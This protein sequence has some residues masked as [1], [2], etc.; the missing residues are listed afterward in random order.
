[1]FSLTN[2]KDIIN[3]QA[4]KA[5]WERLAYYSIAVIGKEDVRGIPE[6]GTGVPICYKGKYFIITCSHIIRGVAEN[7]L[8]FVP[9]T[10]EALVHKEK[11]ELV[12]G[13]KDKKFRYTEMMSLPIKTIHLASPAC[14]DLAAIE[15]D[16]TIK[17]NNLNLCF[18]NLCSDNVKAPE[19]KLRVHLMGFAGEIAKPFEDKNINKRGF[20]L[21][22]LKEVTEIMEGNISLN[23]FYPEHHF[24]MKYYGDYQ[25]EGMSGCGIWAFEKKIFSPIWHVAPNLVGIQSGCYRPSK[26]LKGEKI[27]NLFQLLDNI[28][29]A[30]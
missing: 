4:E 29:E 26:L 22:L 25:P 23:N 28:I 1:M 11:N 18:F 21:F 30:G 14:I 19:V 13:M 16:D 20:V 15:L 8:R 2:L 27:D 3:K 7:K 17:K 9:R 6:H 10:E 5:L 12:E 24:F